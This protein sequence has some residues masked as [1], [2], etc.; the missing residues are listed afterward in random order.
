M[1]NDRSAQALSDAPASC[2]L[3]STETMHPAVISILQLQPV[4]DDD[5]L[6]VEV[7]AAVG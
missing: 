3:L 6:T 1:S 4:T 5:G 2:L 7:G